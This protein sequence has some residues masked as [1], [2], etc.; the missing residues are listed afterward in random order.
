M[1]AVRAALVLAVALVLQAGLGKLFPHSHRYVDVLLVPVAL[2]GVTSSQ[3]AAMLMGCVAGLL[4]DTWFQGGPFGLSGF[5]RTLLGWALGVAATRFDLNQPVGR[6]TLG[7]L[8]SIADDALDLV[9]RGLLDV[10]P[11]F[12]GPVALLVRAGLC[13]SLVAV[14]G[15][16]LDRGRRRAPARRA[17]V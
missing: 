13:G 12:P 10:P 9:L 3:R 5:K 15:L 14:G 2:Y 17:A 1:S 4:T 6:V 11:A 16:I 7:A 8:L